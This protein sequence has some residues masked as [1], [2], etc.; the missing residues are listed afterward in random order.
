M[1]EW[2]RKEKEG[3]EGGKVYFVFKDEKRSLSLAASVTKID[4]E[5]RR[6]KVELF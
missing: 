3:K 6:K 5:K 2:V 4:E 1:S